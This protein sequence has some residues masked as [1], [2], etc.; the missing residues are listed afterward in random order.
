MDNIAYTFFEEYKKLQRLCNDIYDSNNG[1]T[2]YI[3]D[4][5]AVP[6]DTSCMISNW[7]SDLKQLKRLRHIRNT[8]A[9]EEG[10]F[11]MNMCTLSDVKWIQS[12]YNRILN[13]SDPLSVLHQMKKT[14]PLSVPHQVKK[15]QPLSVSHQTKIT[16]PHKKSFTK[17]STFIAVYFVAITI[18]LVVTLILYFILSYM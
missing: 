18:I 3:D 4:M 7:M 15:T 10:S 13:Q 12:F 16:Q 8:L 17:K 14:Q 11:N 6:Y 9:H 5:N 1:V 2:N